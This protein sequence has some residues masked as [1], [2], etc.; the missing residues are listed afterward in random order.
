LKKQARKFQKEL[1]QELKK[2]YQPKQDDI[3]FAKTVLQAVL[4]NFK[5]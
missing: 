4:K 2:D 3:L 1:Y 5:N